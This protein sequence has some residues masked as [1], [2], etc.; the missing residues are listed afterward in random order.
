MAVGGDSIKKSEQLS[1]RLSRYL[2]VVIF[3][4][5]LL[6]S[7]IV[8]W[9]G[10]QRE[11]DQK[12]DF[13][14]GTAKVF[15]ASI[16]EPLAAGD[17]RAVQKA[18]TGIGKFSQYEFAKVMQPDGTS[19]AEMGYGVSL[20]TS[21]ETAHS[22][23]PIFLDQIWVSDKIVNAGEEIGEIQL[24]ADISN[25]RDAFLR[26]LIMNLLLA[27]AAGM[28]ATLIAR[29]VIN[30]LTNPV[31]E[32][33]LLM[34][35]LGEKADFSKRADDKLDGEIGL[36]AT[37]FNRMLSDIEIRDHRLLEYQNTLELRVQDR[38]RALADAKDQA[39]QA[40]AAKSDF[41]AT[42]SHEI[43]TPMN[44]ML[45]MSE[46]LATA[47]L[48]PR[49]Q[50]YAEIIMKSSKSLL[51]II[52]DILDF[53]K[54]Q[55]GKLE[56]EVTEIDIKDLV[57]DVMSLFWQRAAE[58]NLDLA[59]LIDEDVPLSFQGDPVRINQVLSNLVN[60]ALKFTE[61]GSVTI[62][63]SIERDTANPDLVFAVSD[64]GIGIEPD[65][66][67]KVFESFS[68]A[69]QSTTRRFGGTGLGLPI[70]RS[71]TAAMGGEIDVR[72][73]V[74]EGSEF[75]FSVPLQE[76]EYPA[77][78]EVK[79]LGRA[80]I[81]VDKGPT[82]DALSKVAESFGY[83]VDLRAADPDSFEP[84]QRW[85]LIISETEALKYL[86]PATNGQ[87][88][89][90]LTKLGDNSLEMLVHNNQVHDYIDKPVSSISV[91]ETI[92]RVSRGKPLG[93]KILDKE[94][95]V[96][97]Y[98]QKFLGAKV[99]V[100]DDNAVNREVI[101]QALSRFGIDPVMVDSG[102]AAIEVYREQEFDLVFMDCSMPEMDGFETTQHLREL[103]QELARTY[104]P[105]VA[106]TAHI[107]EQVRTRIQES[108]MD[109][110][111]IKPF[112]MKSISQS[113]QKWIS[114]LADGSADDIGPIDSNNH[115][116][117]GSSG[118]INE[119]VLDNL[120]EIAGDG[121]EDTIRQLNKLY[122]DHA[123]DAFN[124]LEE[125]VASGNAKAIE[126]A[127][128]ALKSMSMNVGAATLGT[129]C[130]LMEAAAMAK[131]TD[132]AELM[133]S[134]IRTMLDL[135]IEKITMD[136]IPRAETETNVTPSVG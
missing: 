13:L 6:A 100:T 106:L 34:G 129:E 111:I 62:T 81:A 40:N 67:E 12:T 112:T 55:S 37:S 136:D 47:E 91:S 134:R 131:E 36:L 102:K 85:T 90:A 22:K 79:E 116:D 31:H 8:S 135:V 29:K 3:C 11:L 70:C 30:S 23:I 16:A 27:I 88:V 120:R 95:N 60:N 122:I 127:A 25:I 10:F 93:R 61:S 20:L 32:L 72:S 133:L 35:E 110:I 103:E 39:E 33:S 53:S 9:L 64:T 15:S 68:Q 104:T 124:V 86:M 69:D 59:C 128:H 82:R 45:A 73:V 56:L 99:L 58:K 5:T 130:Q 132:E 17:K 18:L 87:T 119:K 49:N 96:N 26:N 118:I 78:R 105:I 51:A 19:F 75:R 66:I 108:G 48:S 4:A 50:R 71:L 44:G 24:L 125:A 76:P 121:F 98:A 101:V 38:T 83:Q 14:Q 126:E 46:L 84:I 94:T 92:D 74:G 115:V 97:P 52:N 2:A 7:G 65:A 80:L 28:S 123:P 54:I 41:L 21:G 42:M 57:E 109:E 117:A 1:Y 113:L 107:A 114:H 89:V 43:R 63:V 77:A